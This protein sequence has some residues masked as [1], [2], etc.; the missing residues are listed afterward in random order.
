MLFTSV[1]VVLCDRE[2][3]RKCARQR[4]PKGFH[5]AALQPWRAVQPGPPGTREVPK[6]QGQPEQQGR[7]AGLRNYQSKTLSQEQ[8][9]LT[10]QNDG[11]TR[12]KHIAAINISFQTGFTQPGEPYNSYYYYLPDNSNLY[13]KDVI[14]LISFIA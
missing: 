9:G 1:R 3:S 2:N 11:K 14:H 13:K 10:I 7:E 12:E 8:R 5:A 4:P 6:Q